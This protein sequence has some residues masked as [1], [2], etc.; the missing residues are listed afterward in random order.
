M[1]Q[2]AGRVKLAPPSRARSSRDP[3]VGPLGPDLAGT[4]RSFGASI[5]AWMCGSGRVVVGIR[6]DP[7][8]SHFA[9][10]KIVLLPVSE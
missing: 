10:D 9:A 7:E 5:I 8:G 3:L 1:S 4:R 2:R 6:R